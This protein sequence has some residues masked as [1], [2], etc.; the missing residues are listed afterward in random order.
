MIRILIVDDQKVIR[1]KLCYMLQ[2][3]SDIE[4]VGIATDGDIALEQIEVLQ[5]DIVLIDIEMPNMN[6][7]NATKIISRKF[8]NI[9]ILVLST[10]DSEEYVAKSLEAGAKGY[11]LKSL[12]EAEL[13]NSVRFIFQGYS[14]IIGPGLTQQLATVKS[15]EVNSSISNSVRNNNSQ[16]DSFDTLELNSK[17]GLYLNSQNGV[18]ATKSESWKKP[19]PKQKKFRWKYWLSGWAVVNLCIWGMTFLYLK[20]KPPTYVSEWS[21]VL[22]GEEKVDFKIP[23][24]GEA[25]ARGNNIIKDI[26][27]RNNILYLAN[28]KFVLLKAAKSM[29]IS[30]T[31]FGEPEIEL[32]DSSAIISLKIIGDSPIQAQLK[33]QALHNSI[34][35]TI[36]SIKINKSK[37]R[38][39]AAHQTVQNDRSKLEQLQNQLNKHTINSDLVSPEQVQLLIGKIE[40]LRDQRQEINRNLEGFNRQIASISGS[41]KLSPQQAEDLLALQADSIFQQHLQQYNQV[42][43]NLTNLQSR[44]TLNAPQVIDEQIKQQE[45]ETAL[46]SRGRWVI[47]KPVDLQMLKKLSLRSN[48]GNKDIESMARNLVSIY[49]SQQILAT[50]KQTLDRQIQELDTRIKNLNKEKIPY[51]NLQ[52][53]IQFAEAILTSKTAK[54]DINADSSP[55]FPN[56]QLLAEPTL[57]DDRNSDDI[58]IPLIGALALTFL[59]TTGLALFAWDKNNPWEI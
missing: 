3:A 22:P 45:I 18:I 40:S 37:Q 36:E 15:G 32:V 52:R 50:K 46:L 16:L 51:D 23:N 26:D 54:L 59:S 57:P 24:I 31:E 2:Q 12:S 53:E 56:I 58:K 7:I 41:L 9:K 44:F 42:T 33:A 28:S 10:F 47:D 39:E 8:P 4:V 1:E 34:L 6:G 21:V 35:E 30:S 11:L 20:F 43:A 49:T 29:D 25:L 19:E 55:A 5:P 38:I 13:H 14:Q 27:P 48:D 17:N